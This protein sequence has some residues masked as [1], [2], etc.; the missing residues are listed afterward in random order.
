MALAPVS[1]QMFLLS[2]HFSD[3]TLVRTRV[4]LLNAL[5]QPVGNSFLKVVF[6]IDVVAGPS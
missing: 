5:P 3:T 2:I 6:N 1:L 4:L